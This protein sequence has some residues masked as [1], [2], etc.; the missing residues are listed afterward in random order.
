MRRNILTYGKN[1]K[2]KVLKS[3]EQ[4]ATDTFWCFPR[5]SPVLRSSIAT[6]FFLEM[7]GYVFFDFHICDGRHKR[8]FRSRGEVIS[9]NNFGENIFIKALFIWGKVVPGRRVTR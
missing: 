2:K 9:G 7:L 3:S 5:L 6:V 8:V 4:T 1:K